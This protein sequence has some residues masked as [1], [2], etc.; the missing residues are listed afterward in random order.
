VI[1]HISYIDGDKGILRYRCVQHVGGTDPVQCCCICLVLVPDSLSQLLDILSR[2]LMATFFEL[3][4]HS[5]NTRKPLNHSLQSAAMVSL[6]LGAGGPGELSPFLY[7][8]IQ[9]GMFG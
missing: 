1:S 4:G 7:A 9:Q 3:H 2:P 6:S 8:C 5:T